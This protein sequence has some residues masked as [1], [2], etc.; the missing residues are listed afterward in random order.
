[1]KCS[2]LLF[3]LYLSF[4]IFVLN[5]YEISFSIIVCMIKESWNPS[6]LKITLSFA[7]STPIWTKTCVQF[8]ALEFDIARAK[9]VLSVQGINTKESLILIPFL[10]KKGCFSLVMKSIF[11][12]TKKFANLIPKNISNGYQIM[13][14]FC[15]DTFQLVFHSLTPFSP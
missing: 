7:T 13:W 2:S 11:P 14:L 15:I 5:P 6:S 8:P 4:P 1:M 12:Y 3:C 10:L 9:N